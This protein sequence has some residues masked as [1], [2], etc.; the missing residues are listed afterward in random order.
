V[1][2]RNALGGVDS[3]TFK[4]KNRKRL[5]TERSTYN[6][7]SDVFGTT[8]FDEVWQAQYTESL[9]LNSDWLTDAEFLWLREMFLTSECWVLQ[10]ESLVE[11]TIVPTTY[12]VATRAVDRLQQ[13]NIQIQIAYKNTTL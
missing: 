3:Y 12:N 1:Y 6:R 5:E 7:N 10:N 9:D 11:A 2:F 8:S 4:M 13:L